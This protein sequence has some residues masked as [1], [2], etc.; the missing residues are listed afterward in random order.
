MRLK[1]QALRHLPAHQGHD[2]PTT[3]LESAVRVAREQQAL[4]LE[5]RAASDLAKL[6]VADGRR[7]Q[8][9]E[10]L[11]PIL[12]RFT[13]GEAAHDVMQAKTLLNEV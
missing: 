3:L 7:D 11:A 4:S 5:L 12:A 13:E 8:A 2:R 9:R 10:L 1:A 6:L